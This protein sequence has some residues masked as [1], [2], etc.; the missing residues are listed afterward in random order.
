M[1]IN[2]FKKIKKG[3]NVTKLKSN[4]SIRTMNSDILSL[5]KK[6]GD[7]KASPPD[8]LPIVESIVESVK[9]LEARAQQEVEREAMDEKEKKAR[10]E[11]ERQRLL[12]EEA[13]K[14]KKII[15]EIKQERIKVEKERI[16][17]QKILEEEAEK[18]RQ[19][20]AERKKQ[21][22]IKRQEEIKRQ[23]ELE[24]EAERKKQEEAERKRIRAEKKNQRQEKIKE[25]KM[26]LISNTPKLI[27]GLTVI[28][29][30]IGVGIFLYW[31]NYIRVAPVVITHFECQNKQ[32]VEVIGEGES[33]CKIDSDCNPIVP[34]EPVIPEKLISSA[35]IE[36]I[37]LPIKEY[38]LFLGELES[39]FK[40]D[41]EKGLFKIVLTKLIKQTKKEYADFDSFLVISKINIPENIQSI[42]ADDGDIDGNNYN[43]FLYNNGENN[44]TGLIISIDQNLN[45]VE[46]FKAWEETMF[47]DIKSLIFE[48]EVL[49]P[50]IKEFQDNIYNE[51]VIRYINL[52]T[53][54][55][56]IDYAIIED[57]LI[58]TTSKDSMYAIIDN[59]VP[60]NDVE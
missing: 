11:V 29:L 4:S 1:D 23:K 33:K 27:V 28:S 21:K 38:E 60:V 26:R 6:E 39:I 3:E 13:E 8:G 46:N 18:K 24:E 30:I 37:E 57:K 43:L 2:G 31:W 55:L 14:Q 5:S 22:E 20:E 45:L 9:N 7:K 19:E 12:K 40:K 48:D 25:I 41:Q 44:R 32:C 54:D 52:P 47:N 10:E 50:A 58:I 51:V 15:E 59:L 42:I 53:S 49:E 34:I 35:E 17:Q 16:K 56:S 36:I